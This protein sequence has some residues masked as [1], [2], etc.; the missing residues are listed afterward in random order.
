M[1]LIK[2]IRKYS[3]VHLG[4]REYRVVFDYNALA[5]L[6]SQYKPLYDIILKPIDK[7]TMEDIAQML[8]AAFCSMPRN[9]TAVAR[10]EFDKV[11]PDL[12]EIGRMLSI[13][14]LKPLKDELTAAII[15]SFPPGNGKEEDSGGKVYDEGNLRAMYVDIMGRPEAEFWGSTPKEIAYRIDK[16]AESKGLKDPPIRFKEFDDD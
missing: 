7:W 5:C 15:E 3:I 1:S 14:E 9:R 4:G 6:E 12:W 10:R 11:R 2:M 13:D 8:R 16:Y